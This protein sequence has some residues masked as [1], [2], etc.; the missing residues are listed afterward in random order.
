MGSSKGA[1]VSR[2]RPRGQ[3]KY[4]PFENLDA[5]SLR[6]VQRFSVY[7]FGRIAECCAHIPYNSGKKDFFEKTGRES[8]EGESIIAGAAFSP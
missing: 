3:I 2:T 5:A 1:L 4:P 8:F 7:P 6:E